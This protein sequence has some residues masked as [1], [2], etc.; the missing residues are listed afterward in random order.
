MLIDNLSD[1]PTHAILMLVGIALIGAAAIIARKKKKI[2]KWMIKHKITAILGVFSCLAG[3]GLGI[4]MVG[5]NFNNHIN[6]IHSVFGLIS[7]SF[8]SFTPLI[9][10]SILWTVK[11][12]RPPKKIRSIRL[13]HKWLGRIT[14]LIVII[15][16]SLG[17]LRL[18]F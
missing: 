5:E 7:I 2:T 8:L 1:W 16:I 3:L 9:G 4:R 14:I 18:F 17:T 12:K 10:Q 13:F 15:T 11:K 6:S